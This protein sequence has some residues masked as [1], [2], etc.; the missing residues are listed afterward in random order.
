M[1]KEFPR[2]SRVRANLEV[3]HR[4]KRWGPGGVERYVDSVV[5]HRTNR[6]G[7]G[8]NGGPDMSHANLKIH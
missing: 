6:G 2:N 5:A 1:C 4:T 3:A 7:R 8:L